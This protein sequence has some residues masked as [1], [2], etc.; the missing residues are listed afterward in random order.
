M[1]YD[2]GTDSPLAHV[3]KPYTNRRV[4]FLPAD[5]FAGA[6]A[7]SNK[8]GLLFSAVLGPVHHASDVSDVWQEADRLQ[9]WYPTFVYIDWTDF[10]LQPDVSEILGT[11]KPIHKLHDSVARATVALA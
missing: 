4:E 1:R 7:C 8:G 3:G 10:H 2:R 9:K 6:N 5:I 11:L